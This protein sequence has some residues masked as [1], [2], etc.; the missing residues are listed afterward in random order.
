MV[1]A[2]VG[3]V[4]AKVAVRCCAMNDAIGPDLLVLRT[5]DA[6]EFRLVVLPDRG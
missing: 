2:Y 3:Y 6:N 1:T 4:R 5:S